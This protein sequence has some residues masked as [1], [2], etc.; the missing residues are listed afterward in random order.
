M[1]SVLLTCR[2]FFD[3]SL[4]VFLDRKLV[5]RQEFVRCPLEHLLA[6]LFRQIESVEGFLHEFARG[7]IGSLASIRAILRRTVAGRLI[8]RVA[9]RGLSGR[10]VR[11]PR[12]GTWLVR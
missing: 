4:E 7:E 3:D 5:A 2:L 12:F 10:L 1:N 11:L 9:S 8:G 6:V